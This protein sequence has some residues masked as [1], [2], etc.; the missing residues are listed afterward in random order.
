M[1]ESSSPRRGKWLSFGKE[2]AALMFPDTWISNQ[3]LFLHL[4]ICNF[5]YH[6]QI[7]QAATG[8]FSPNPCWWAGRGGERGTDSN[9]GPLRKDHSQ[10]SLPTLSSWSLQ[11]LNIYFIPQYTSPLQSPFSRV[12]CYGACRSHS[13]LDWNPD[14]DP[15]L[16]PY[17][18]LYYLQQMNEMKLLSY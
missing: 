6:L 7:G 1:S 10:F 13:K 2:R 11:A 5:F 9:Q 16:Q 3:H 4:I 8:E 17:K 18:C 15:T 12:P 14:L